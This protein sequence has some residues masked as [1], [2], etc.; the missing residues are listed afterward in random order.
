MEI[1]SG[2]LGL[3]CYKPT[4]IPDEFVVRVFEMAGESGTAII[5]FH[6]DIESVTLV[7]LVENEIGELSFEGRSVHLPIDGHSIVTLRMKFT[8]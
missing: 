1:E 2:T 8:S 6:R 3:S 4:D 7:D 5:N